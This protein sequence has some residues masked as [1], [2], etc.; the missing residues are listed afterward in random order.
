MD[1][2]SLSIQ[3]AIVAVLVGN[4]D[5]GVNVFD[6]VPAS[7]LPEGPFPRITLGEGQSAGNYA[8][9]YEGTETTLVIDVWSRA[10][11][12][13]EAKRIASQVRAILHDA[14][15]VLDDHILDLIAFESALNLRDPD[16]ITRHVAITFRAL[17][18]PSDET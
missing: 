3:K 5:A 8:D 6:Q 16:G 14:P 4:T 7:P 12:F 1:D 17:T 18:Q 9:C 11:G 2:P 13:P 15:L 10:V